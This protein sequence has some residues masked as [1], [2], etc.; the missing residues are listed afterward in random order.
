MA[1]LQEWHLR[2]SELCLPLKWKK[3]KI[4]SDPPS[5]ICHP[6]SDLIVY[7]CSSVAGYQL[8]SSVWE[9]ACRLEAWGFKV[10]TLTS[11]GASANCKFLNLHKP[12][13]DKIVYKTI[14]PYVNQ[15]QVVSSVFHI[16]TA[17]PRKAERF[18]PVTAGQSDTFGSV[19]PLAP[20]RCFTCPPPPAPSPMTARRSGVSG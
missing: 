17:P 20:L 3:F 12:P 10:I 13:T 19:W 15:D 6:H 18:I 14:N 9:C 2:I 4:S 8:H 11:D 1:T 16:W 5:Y 7:S